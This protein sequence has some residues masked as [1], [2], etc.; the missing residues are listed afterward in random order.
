MPLVAH[1]AL[2]TFEKLHKEGQTVLSVDKA[3]NQD[4]R[5]LHIGL[6]N[7]MPDTALAATE[8]QFMR[9]IGKSNPIAQFYVH[10][11]T[12]PELKRSEDAQQHIDAYYESFED[13][14]SRGLDSL[15]I[16]GAAPQ[17]ESLPNEPFWSP[18]FEVIDWAHENVTSTLCSCLTTHAI[19]QGRYQQMRKPLVQK[20]WGVFPHWVTNKEHPLVSDI[21][22]HF[23]VPHSRWNAVTRSQFDAAGLHTLVE[24]ETGVHLATSPDGIRTVF[25]QGHPEYDTISLLKEYKR[26][27]QRYARGEVEMPP[28]FPE[29]Y[30]KTQE[31][32]ILTEYIGRLTDARHDKH[33]AI[34]DFP[35]TK[36]ARRLQNTW[37]DTATAVIGN[38][39]GCVYQLTHRERKKPFM[40]GINPNNP[41]KLPFVAE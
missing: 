34:P 28:A 12:L 14:Q 31:K 32:A 24:S 10:L 8:R 3:L 33:K 20:A 38:W 18:L 27:A 16:T 17:S 35:E 9:L 2:P 23:D 7:I 5:D 30:F 6:L 21:N 13:I 26:E 41:L 15:I 29:H 39:M 11:F 1:N 37:T 36:I 19:L 22:T 25:F 40:D 4:I